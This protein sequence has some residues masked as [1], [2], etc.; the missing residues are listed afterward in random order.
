MRKTQIIMNKPIYFGLSILDLSKHITYE[1]WYDYIKPKYGEYI[2]IAY[3]TETRFG[4]SNYELDRPWPKKIK[5]VIELMKDKSG[6][7]ILKRLVGLGAKTYSYLKDGSSED[8]KA[9][10][11]KNVCHKKKT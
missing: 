10:V 7:K 9:K 4:T 2:D 6:G 1:F 8:K 11:I 3:D 5:R